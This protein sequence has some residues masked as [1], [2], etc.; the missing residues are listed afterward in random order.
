MFLLNSFENYFDPDHLQIRYGYHK[1]TYLLTYLLTLGVIPG[2]YRT[3][4]K[5]TAAIIIRLRL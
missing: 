5:I 1:C 4:I 3:N 2:V